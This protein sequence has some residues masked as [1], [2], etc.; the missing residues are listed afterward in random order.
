M[1][2][3]LPNPFED[4]KGQ[5]IEIDRVR[6]RNLIKTYVKDIVENTRGVASRGDLYVGDA[7]KFVV[8]KYALESECIA[9]F[10]C[11]CIHDLLPTSYRHC[12]YV[13]SFVS[14]K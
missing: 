11:G 9:F 10:V 12:I 7:G 13:S 14:N 5:P 1:D 2:R 8:S 4:Y 3:F 6:I